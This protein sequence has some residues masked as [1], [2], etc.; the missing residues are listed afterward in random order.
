MIEL[1]GEVKT[2]A[3]TPKTPAAC[4]SKMHPLTICAKIQALNLIIDKLAAIL[5]FNY[6]LLANP[7]CTKFSYNVAGEANK[8]Y[9]YEYLMLQAYR[10]RHLRWVGHIDLSATSVPLSM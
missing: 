1:T 5:R 6:H 8:S 10:S 4:A 9:T 7:S 3:R 2:L